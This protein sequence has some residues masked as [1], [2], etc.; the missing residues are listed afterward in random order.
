MPSLRKKHVESITKMKTNT[1]AKK[2]SSLSIS[3][4]L[5]N[6]SFEATASISVDQIISSIF[7]EYTKAAYLEVGVPV[8]M[9]CGRI[10]VAAPSGMNKM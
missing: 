9:V 6:C 2:T 7:A 8:D 10:N 1:A 3:S 5:T 4:P